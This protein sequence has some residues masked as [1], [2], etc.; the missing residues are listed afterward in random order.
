M[1]YR[2]I[3]MNTVEKIGRNYLKM[4]GFKWKAEK[5]KYFKRN[6]AEV[7]LSFLYFLISF[8]CVIIDEASILVFVLNALCLSRIILKNS[9]LS[10]STTDYIKEKLAEKNLSDSEKTPN[11]AIGKYYYFH[12]GIIQ[13]TLLGFSVIILIFMNL[14]TS[15]ILIK[16][17]TFFTMLLVF[18]DDLDSMFVNTFDAYIDPIV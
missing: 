7:L 3:A 18:L 4:V 6:L 17:L 12:K 14:N 16:G 1:Y 8:I 2:E 15:S 9:M 11:N 5:P 10:S 13:L